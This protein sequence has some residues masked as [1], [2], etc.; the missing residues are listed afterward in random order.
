MKLTIER[1]ALLGALTTSTACVP[2]R[3]SLPI[4][5]CVRL[6][7]NGNFTVSASDLNVSLSVT[8]QADVVKPNAA[9]VSGHRLKSAIGMMRGDSVGIEM[10]A[11]HLIFEDGTACLR[12]PFL[13]AEEFPPDPLL[14]VTNEAELELAPALKATLPF[15][16]EPGRQR[17]ILEGV[18]LQ[19]DG[20]DAHLVAVDGHSCRTY[21]LNKPIDG[22]AIIPTKA[23]TLMSKVSGVGKLEFAE[24]GVRMTAENYS[25]WAQLI[26]GQYPNW[27]QP[28]PEPEESD[29]L[30]H[31]QRD[32]FL[33]AMDFA[34]LANP[35]D[36]IIRLSFDR[37]A[38][39]M[40]TKGKDN[41]QCRTEVPN[42]TG[43]LRKPICFH[44]ELLGR[45]I[46]S[47]DSEPQV[48]R[49]KSP[50]EPMTISDAHGVA[51]ICPIRTE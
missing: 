21:R 23:A 16:C 25:I 4:L 41:E 34:A 47:V 31:I 33:R 24:N 32:D 42:A 20:R 39:I 40:E 48:L 29:D 6:T 36:P 12:L 46:D 7:A 44:A 10:K 2:T 1:K 8:A 38:L 11:P 27:R 22:E 5:S 18:C 15:V 43:G 3:V 17:F 37:E 35:D 14:D 19:G 28:I 9:C 51:V 50:M 30:I 49:I 13:P 45:A 26:E